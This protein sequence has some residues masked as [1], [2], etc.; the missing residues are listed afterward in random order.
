MIENTTAKEF[1]LYLSS[2]MTPPLLLKQ[3]IGT[4]RGKKNYVLLCNQLKGEIGLRDFQ[5]KEESSIPV[6][7]YEKIAIYLID[8]VL[9]LPSKNIHQNINH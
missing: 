2:N 4:K 9:I 1:T 5:R 3:N 7:Y 8:Q 6:N